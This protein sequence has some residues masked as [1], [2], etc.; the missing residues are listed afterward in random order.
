M[1]LVEEVSEI[2]KF[3]ENEKVAYEMILPSAK[4]MAKTISSLTNT[5]GGYL[6]IGISLEH[7]L[8]GLSSDFNTNLIT[9]KARKLLVPSLHII[10]EFI[11]IKNK[12]LFVIKVDKSTENILV[13]DKKYIRIG[14]KTREDKLHINQK[15]VSKKEYDKT[16]AIIISLEK[17]APRESDHISSVKYANNDAN[18]FKS[19][20]INQM[21]VAEKDITIF[22][23]DNAM[24]SSLEYDL[25]GLFHAL[26]EKDR[27]I[28]YY[29]G[30]GFHDGTTNYLSTYDMHPFNITQ[31]A[32]SLRDIL[33]DPFSKSK[34]KSALV[35]IDACATNIQNENS[36]NVLSN[37]NY[38]DLFKVE[39]NNNLYSATFFSCQAG[40]SSY[41]CDELEHGIW[42]Y[43]LNQ[44]I[45]GYEP[46]LITNNQFISDRTLVDYLT[47]EVYKYTKEKLGYE[48]N[49]KAVLDADSEFVLVEF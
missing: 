48:Q 31:T 32:I 13:E 39:E 42:T 21:N 24:K 35:F 10:S 9:L 30:H 16:Y 27:L 25:K 11:V 3:S 2:I 26:T 49:P 47:T 5:N 40:Q 17:Y 28:F 7:G 6:I 44:A 4:S 20:L 43:Y 12:N 1:S 8:K 46:T 23:N 38:H 45:S 37:I 34:C 36:R 15:K 29:V 33:L 22:M 41:S 19:M 14:S 18:L